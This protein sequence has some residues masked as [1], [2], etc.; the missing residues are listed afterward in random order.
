MALRVLRSG[1]WEPQGVALVLGMA[2]RCPADLLEPVLI[3]GGFVGGAIGPR[4]SAEG[5]RRCQ[6]ASSRRM[7]GGDLDLL[8]PRC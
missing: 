5:P 8:V 3:T 1:A 7:L 6:V 4:A 2:A